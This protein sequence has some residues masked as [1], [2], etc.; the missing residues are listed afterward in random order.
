MLRRNYRLRDRKSVARVY[1]QGKT[2]R[3]GK[4]TMRY[5]QNH[6]DSTRL[7][8]VVSKKV[9]KSAPLRNR[10]RRRLSETFRRKWDTIKPGYD[11]IISV[12]DV[13]AATMD[14]ADLDKLTDQLL[15]KANLYP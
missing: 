6:T 1:R 3:T 13:S 4:L 12:H 8:V 11:I 14:Q 5:T 10:I 9:A 15:S 7:A 2:A